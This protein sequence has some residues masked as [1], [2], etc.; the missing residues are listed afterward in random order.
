M[1]LHFTHESSLAICSYSKM[2]SERLPSFL[3]RLIGEINDARAVR[4]GFDQS[5]R[6]VDPFS[7]ETLSPPQDKRHDHEQVLIDEVQG[8]EEQ[9]GMSC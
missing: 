1:P 3:Y 6:R 8:Q 2:V 9:A 5:E 7:K 4:L